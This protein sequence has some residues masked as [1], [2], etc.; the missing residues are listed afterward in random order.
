MEF[1]TRLKEK[2]SS[3]KFAIFDIDESKIRVV[4][5]N[6]KIYKKEYPLKEGI[7]ENG[8]IKNTLEFEAYLEEI[9]KDF[10]IEK[11]KI[12]KTL[13]NIHT[14]D[15]YAIAMKVPDMPKE[16]LDEFIKTNIKNLIPFSL[17]EVYFTYR[18]YGF[19]ETEKKKKITLFAVK[20]L[21]VDIYSQIFV[22]NNFLP[23]FIGIDAFNLSFLLKKKII[24]NFE[25]NYLF[26]VSKTDD[27]TFI[28]INEL[29]LKFIWNKKI[30]SKEKIK[31]LLSMVERYITI[32]EKKEPDKIFLFSPP[33]YQNEYLN[34]IKEIWNEKNIIT[35]QFK[36]DEWFVADELIL[37][38]KKFPYLEFINIVSV[39]PEIEYLI[40]RTK[41]QINFWILVAIAFLVIVNISFYLINNYGNDLF[42]KTKVQTFKIPPYISQKYD[43]MLKEVKEFNEMTNKV[44]EVRQIEFKFYK[45]LNFISKLPEELKIESVKFIDNEIIMN[46]SLRNVDEF[47][48][49]KNFL[50]QNQ[51]IESFDIPI[52][53]IRQDINLNFELKI[54]LK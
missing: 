34:S 8:N 27:V 33:Q 42:E 23:I 1:I 49:F 45:H 52:S 25:E 47:N 7:I 39:F 46:A 28:F 20:K 54:R 32:S 13:I 12:I 22:K 48:M 51:E 16:N 44:K 31:E 18:I 14:S 5:S 30:E 40:L 11:N 29:Q 43:E 9:K 6:G 19:D 26:I 2:I 17:E 53:K 3:K 21:L 36:E 50:K 37:E 35:P 4:F 41:E 38:A 24:I 10:E 15:F